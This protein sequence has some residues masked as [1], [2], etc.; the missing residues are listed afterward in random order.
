MFDYILLMQAQPSPT[1]SLMSML[2]AMLMMFGVFYLLV[3]RPQSKER[4]THENFVKG[5]KSGDLVVTT[6][7]LLGKVKS[8]DGNVVTLEVSK[9]TRVEF[10]KSQIQGT[11]A[12]LVKGESG[13]D[14]K[15]SNKGDA[16]DEGSW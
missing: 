6:G 8:V 5:L 14:D 16:G 10:L 11:Q 13:D 3:W 12:K 4:Q 7:G 1:Q 9:G 15:E 2:P